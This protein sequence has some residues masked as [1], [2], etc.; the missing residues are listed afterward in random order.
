VL[1]TLAPLIGVPLVL[2][3]IHLVWLELIVHPVSAI[4]FQAEPASLDIMSRPPRDPVAPLL[5]R[6]SVIRSSLSGLVLALASF[7]AYWWQWQSLGETTARALALVVL[8]AG[9]QTLM[10]AE[11]VA[12]PGLA[13][14]L[15]PGTRVFWAVWTAS[16]LSLVVLLSVDVVAATFRVS[17][18]EGRYLVAAVAAGVLSV[19]WRLWRPR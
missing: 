10:F 6:P 1:A 15:L 7:T 12:L 3:P 2:L 18:P 11:R 9:Y 17:V 14:N 16:L 13:V 19:G 5:P 4:V 8:L